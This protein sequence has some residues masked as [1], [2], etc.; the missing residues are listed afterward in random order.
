MNVHVNDLLT[1][2]LIAIRRD[3]HQHPELG[4]KEFRTAGIVAKELTELGIPFLPEAAGTGTGVVA[5]LRKGEGPTIVL[6]ADMDALPIQERTALPFASRTE[7]RMHA[8]GHDVHTTMLLGAAHLLKDR[9]FRGCI[10]LVFQPSE[11][12]V[13]DDPERKSGGQRIVESGLLDDAAAAL[14]L[15][16][17]PM[18]PAGKIFFAKGEALACV[19]FFQIEVLGRSGHAG[20]APE[21]AID[22]I[23]VAANVIQNLQ[24]IVSRNI[25]PMRPGVIS[26]TMIE[27]GE[28]ENIIADRVVMKGTIRAL[29]LSTYHTILR[30]IDEMLKGIS[31]T[32]HAQISFS[33]IAE[34]PSVLNDAAVHTLLEEPLRTTFGKDNVIEEE[35]MMGGEDFAFFSRKM[36]SMFYFIGAQD[37]AKETF[38]LHHPSVVINEGCIPLGAR[39]LAAGALR[40]LAGLTSG[41]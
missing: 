24:T 37:T 19:N 36:P 25:P 23:L 38:F 11:E 7:N 41:S 9:E 20:A 21:L 28:K 27:G 35:P 30:R 10:K 22:A 12:G 8:C 6:R 17:H 14:A 15:H 13:Y 34:Y 26:V 2:H 33:V 32:F 31:L 1:D 16:V 3:L 4:Y 5:T 40:L 18:R 29:D 39:F